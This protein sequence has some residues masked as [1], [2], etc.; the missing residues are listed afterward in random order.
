MERIGV[1]TR[2]AKVCLLQPNAAGAG[3]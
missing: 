3:G 1:V 2:R